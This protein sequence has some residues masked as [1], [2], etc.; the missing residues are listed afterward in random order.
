[1]RLIR[2][3][4]VLGAGF[5]AE[6]GYPLA[7]DL[8]GQ[9]L[10]FLS[11][12]GYSRSSR[13]PEIREGIRRADGSQER[14]FEDL[15]LE[16]R[17]LR[18]AEPHAP[19]A[20]ADKH[21][22]IGVRYVLWAIHKRSDRV[23]PSYLR[24]GEWLRASRER[25]AIISFNWDLHVERVLSDVR[26]P[27]RYWPEDGSIPVIK[28]H[29]SINWNDHKR[30]GL[31]PEYGR[32]EQILRTSISYDGADPLKNPELDEV[33]PQLPYLLYPGDTRTLDENDDAKAVWAHVDH[34]LQDVTKMAFVGYSFP[35][36][37]Q[38]ASAYF[39][40]KV[41]GR[42]VMIVNP[43]SDDL[44]RAENVLVQSASRLESLEKTFGCACQD[45][46]QWLSRTSRWG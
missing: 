4:V 39:G 21:L 35:D 34:V 25:V 36:Y 17:R 38:D 33:T 12:S 18:Q 28:P 1:M 23:H 14:Q 24:F 27:W 13:F 32:W 40:E 22:R 5:S 42:E 8:R 16:L 15:M 43:S 26:A 6:Q 9:V 30:Q 41:R 20:T 7:R 44:A 31:V 46:G 37:D 2:T 29:G 19:V 3:A 11:S 10:D 45:I